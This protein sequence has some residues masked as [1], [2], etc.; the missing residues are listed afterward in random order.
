LAFGDS[1][2]DGVGSETGQIDRWPNFLARRLGRPSATARQAS[3][4]RGSAATACFAAP[5]V[6]GRAAWRASSGTA[7]SEPGVRAVIVLEASTTI[8]FAQEPARPAQS[9]SAAHDR[10]PD[11]GRLP[12][13]DRHGARLGIKIYLGT[14]TPRQSGAAAREVN[15]DSWTSHAADE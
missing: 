8:D 15:R 2:T 9:R 5:A 14:L 11:R 10:R 7:L 6:S 12:P 3:S 13:A 4:T 1:I